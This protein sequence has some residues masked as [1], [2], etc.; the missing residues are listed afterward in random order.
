MTTEDA[1]KQRRQQSL[2]RIRRLAT[3]LDDAVRIPVV[4]VRVGLDPVIGLLPGIGDAA[5]LLLSSAAIVEALRLRAPRRVV[6][7]M[8]RNLAVDFGVGLIP[9]AGD[10]FDIYWKANRR[11]LGVLE[12]WLATETGTRTTNRWPSVLLTGAVLAIALAIT[13]GVWHNMVEFI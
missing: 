10:V 2:I 1:L 7:R 6:I 3:W 13:F 11:N 4:G 8:L 12:E 5:G 9:V